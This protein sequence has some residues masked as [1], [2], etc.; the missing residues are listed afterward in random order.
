MLT[1][2]LYQIPVFKGAQYSQH[3]KQPKPGVRSK[4]G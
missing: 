2:E 1:G 3:I 4:L